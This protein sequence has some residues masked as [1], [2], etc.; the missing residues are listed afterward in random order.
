MTNTGRR[1]ALLRG[2]NVGGNVKVAMAELRAM[3]E[4]L[5]FTEA[6]TLLQSGNLILTDLKGRSSA[7]IEALL[8]RETKQKL[9]VAPDYMVRTPAEWAAAIAANPFP[10]MAKDD[11]SHLLVY[12]LKGATGPDE[13]AV[14][15][16]NAA[17]VGPEKVAAIG[18]ELF[19][20]YPAGVG[21]SKLSTNLIEKTLGKH[22]GTGRNW[23][24]VLKIAALLG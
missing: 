7:E 5:G 21:T 8:E 6:K 18:R 20:T 4:T 15:R 11:P 13:E 19:I 14:A 17:I 3:V 9:G 23:N 1:V 2:I 16:L 24:T 10:D 12:F 22:R